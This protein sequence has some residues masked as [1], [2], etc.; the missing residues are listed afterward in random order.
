MPFLL[1]LLFFFFF[2]FFCV[3]FFSALFYSF[4]RLGIGTFGR[5]WIV[6]DKGSSSKYYAMKILSKEQIVALNQTIGV[7]REKSIM[8][9]LKSPFIVNLVA[10]H[11]DSTSLY[12][13]IDLLQGG[14]LFSVLHTKDYDGELRWHSHEQDRRREE[15]GGWFNDDI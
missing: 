2:F 1:F 13:I 10:T 6:T 14:E 7:L 15:G 4:P 3:F 8:A 12:L 5:V 9:S 11:K